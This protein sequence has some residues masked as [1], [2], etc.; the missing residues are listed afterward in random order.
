MTWGDVRYEARLWWC[1]DDVC[2]CT[3]PK[4]DLV[5]PNHDAGRP[6]IRRWTIW[7]GTFVTAASSGEID[8]Q[9]RELSQAVAV[10]LIGRLVGQEMPD[11]DWHVQSAKPEEP[12]T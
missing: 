4:I 11:V 3:Q 8:E 2:D 6:W 10:L 5:S 7:A 12:G 9:R 1:G